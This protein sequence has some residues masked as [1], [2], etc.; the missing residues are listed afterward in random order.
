MFAKLFLPLDRDSVD[1]IHKRERRRRR[2]IV[3]PEK[4]ELFLKRLFTLKNSK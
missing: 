4:K 2:V 3:E 1:K